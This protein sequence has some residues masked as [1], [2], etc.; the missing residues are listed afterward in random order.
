[1]RMGE[2]VEPFHGQEIRIIFKGDFITRLSGKIPWDFYQCE[3]LEEKD[4]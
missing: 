2:Y 3:D 1:M 4:N